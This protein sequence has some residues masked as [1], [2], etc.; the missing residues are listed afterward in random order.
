M[1][2][3]ELQINKLFG[4]HWSLFEDAHGDVRRGKYRARVFK[5][6]F[7]VNYR[8]SSKMQLK[9]PGIFKRFLWNESIDSLWQHRH[10]FLENVHNRW[11]VFVPRQVVFV[12][13]CWN[14]ALVMDL[15]MHTLKFL[16]Y[17][18]CCLFAKHIDV[19]SWVQLCTG[20]GKE[21]TKRCKSRW[22]W[23]EEASSFCQDPFVAHR[24]TYRFG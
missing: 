20:S 15:H 10:F 12:T 24:E 4:R 23:L 6:K 21:K 16:S 14:G 5:S 2:L 17:C 7:P 11:R 8:T 13:V 9:F 19:Y 18:H 22:A 1:A 3:D